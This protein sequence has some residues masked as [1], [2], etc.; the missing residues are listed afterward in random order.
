MQAEIE[1]AYRLSGNTMGWRLLAS[2]ESTLNRASISFIGLNPGGSAVTTEHSV[3][4]MPEG[5]SAYV[6][7]LCNV[8]CEPYL[9]V[10]M[11]LQMMFLLAILY[12]SD[13]RIGRVY[14][15]QRDH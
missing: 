12:L 10:W 13:L 2:P 8:R 3:Y 4:A 15:T 5:Q 11:C 6:D 7:A 9:L 14:G 1:H